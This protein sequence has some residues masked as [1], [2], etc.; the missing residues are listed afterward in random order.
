MSRL[1]HAARSEA[2]SVGT[3]CAVVTCAADLSAGHAAGGDEQGQRHVRR[4]SCLSSLRP[5]GDRAGPFRKSPASD[6]SAGGSC[7]C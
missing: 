3:V 4:T 6:V 5:L 2:S 7:S 1:R